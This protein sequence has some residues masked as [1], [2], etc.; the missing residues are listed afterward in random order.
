MAEKKRELWADYAKGICILLVFIGHSDA[1]PQAVRIFIYL[2]HMPM[3]FFCMGY[4]SSTG[5]TLGGFVK[6]RFRQLMVPFF[7]YGIL[8]Q[9]LF[10]GILVSLLR[11]GADGDPRRVGGKVPCGLPHDASHAGHRDACEVFCMVSVRSQKG[12]LES[13]LRK[14]LQSQKERKYISSKKLHRMRELFA[15][16]SWSKMVLASSMGLYFSFQV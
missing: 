7:A 16:Y 11:G 2:F 10:L 1:I 4:Y 13:R 5:G 9:V 6:K 3:F 14:T 15:A 8:Y 12:E